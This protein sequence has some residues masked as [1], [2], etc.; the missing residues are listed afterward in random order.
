M[1][2]QFDELRQ[3]V[4]NANALYLEKSARVSEIDKVREQASKE[5]IEAWGKLHAAEARLLAFVK[6]SLGM[7]S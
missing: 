7:T 3:A 5:S 1:T 6:G 4:R 2:S